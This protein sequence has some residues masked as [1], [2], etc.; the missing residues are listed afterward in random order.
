MRIVSKEWSKT[1]MMIAQVLKATSCSKVNYLVKCLPEAVP[2]TR[3]RFKQIADKNHPEE[4]LYMGDYFVNKKTGGKIYFES[5]KEKK[6]QMPEF[7]KYDG[8]KIELSNPERYDLEEARF[9]LKELRRVMLIVAE[10]FYKEDVEPVDMMFQKFCIKP[11]INSE[12]RNGSETQKQE[13]G[14]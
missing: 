13:N 2:A 7:K 14:G 12:L 11:E 3:I 4:F 6:I 1:A 8:I 5:E 9:A 10:A